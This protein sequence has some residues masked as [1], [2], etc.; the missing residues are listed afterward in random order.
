LFISDWS[1]SFSAATRARRLFKNGQF[2]SSDTATAILNAVGQIAIGQEIGGTGANQYRG[3]IDELRFWTRTLTDIELKNA[4][5][6]QF[7]NSANLEAYYKFNE[8]AGATQTIYDYSGNS[9]T[10]TVSSSSLAFSDSSLCLAQISCS[11]GD[12][13]DGHIR[14][15]TPG[16]YAITTGTISLTNDVSFSIWLRRD[17]LGSMYAFSLGPA[18][19]NQILHTGFRYNDAFVFGFGGNDMVTASVHTELGSWIRK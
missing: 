2:D 7:T 17:Q 15:V 19:V 14:F 10:L 4:F 5:Q 11:Q 3:K 18:S 8:P 12:Q 6:N 13:D 1:G 9:R 16:S